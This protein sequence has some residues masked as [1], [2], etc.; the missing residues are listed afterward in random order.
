[1]VCVS[2]CIQ[3]V[4]I[5]VVC[6]FVRKRSKT[7]VSACI[8]YW[9]YLFTIYSR[10]SAASSRPCRPKCRHHTATRN[11]QYQK[12]SRTN[13]HYELPNA[14]EQYW[15]YAS[16][17]MV[18]K[19]HMKNGPLMSASSSRRRLLAA[20]CNRNDSGWLHCKLQRARSWYG[21]GLQKCCLW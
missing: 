5:Y 4:K 21:G 15:S 13:L 19:F 3:T 11:A 12:R 6:N 16:T 10:T 18:P 1:M 9:G 2:T 20:S 17:S 7:L 8:P 14:C